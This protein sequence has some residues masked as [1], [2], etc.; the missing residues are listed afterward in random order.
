MLNP[1]EKTCE[2]LTAAQAVAR[3]AADGANLLPGAKARNTFAIALEVLREPMFLLLVASAGIYLVLGDLS[4]ALVL[5]ASIVVVMV[6]TII[7]ERKSERA[8]EALRDLSSP[9]ALVIRDGAEVRIAG[10]EV[11]RGDLMLLAEGDRVPAD[12]RLLATNDLMVDESL[13]TGESLPA[14]KAAGMAVFSGTLVVKGQGRA[15]VTHT[16]VR[17]E[18]GRIGVSL[19]GLDSEKTRL[20]TETARVV[21]IFATVGLA[22]C[23][24]LMLLYVVGRGGWLQGILA[25]LTL[26]MA[27]LPE[28]FPV[29]LTV[30][31][32]LGAWRIARHGVLTRRMPAIETLGSATVLC[33]DKTGTLTENRMA[34]AD[35]LPADGISTGQVLETAA[36]ACEPEAF[37]PM[38]RAILAAAG[39]AAARLRTE[40]VLEKDYPLN[41]DFLAVC[42]AWR[43][44][45]G[46]RRVVV[47]G[48]A[49]TV[50]ALC[51]LPDHAPEHALAHEA[52]G[53]GLR[54]LGVAEAEWVAGEWPADPRE[55]R[56]RWLGFVGLADPL[57]P[58]VPAAVALCRRA[59]IRVVMVTGDHPG[60]AVA[61]ARSAGIAHEAGV[62]TG[63]EVENLDEAALADAVKRINVF[64]RIRPAQ[65][66]R[67]V[68]AF[69]AAGEI[70]AMTGDGVN[71]APALKAA[72]IGVAMGKRGTDV[73]REAAALVLVGDDFGS[74]VT[75]VEL[76]RRIYQNIRNAMRYILAVHVP[77]AGMA[78]LPLL[79]GGPVLL[80]PVHIV[81]LEF[82]IDPACSIVYEA[83]DS[84]AGLMDRPPRDPAEPLFN[85]NMLLVSFALGLSALVATVVAYG[86]AL[87][88][89]RSEGEVRAI[90][91][92]AIACCNLAMIHSTRSRDLSVFSSLARP[93]AAL[94]WVTC[95]TLAALASALYVPAVAKIFRFAPLSFGDALVPVAAGIAGVAWY[96]AY[97]KLRPKSR[98]ATE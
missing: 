63:T 51:G 9:R 67:L 90:G 2:G 27:I 3:L 48:A 50:L 13:L 92:A 20:Q 91:F 22:L 78:F 54:M 6:I 44:P 21:K 28:E 30:F 45:A 23:V 62:L 66:L 46:T 58:E 53:R 84:D 37:D 83:E 89:G 86:W 61:I 39:S 19:A 69:K 26:A 4:E 15:E 93:N 57:R 81:F 8:L 87:R 43:S 10:A 5:A 17:T 1:A 71:D 35:T 59:G 52:A 55:F 38:E 41:Q 25:G 72:H 74:I 34:V 94:W 60:T 88:S 73:A 7:Q 95:G 79:M 56:F 11:V 49:E 47:K 33:V 14:E 32:A 85:S 76:G 70:V 77:T 98:L 68:Q 42:H 40:W 12:A 16:G 97:K 82:V 29:V 36:L 31:L 64:A 24:V 18:F 80:F 65:K 75:T 96:E